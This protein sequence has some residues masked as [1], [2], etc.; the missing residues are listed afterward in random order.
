[1]AAQRAV[2]AQMKA[3]SSRGRSS[4]YRAMLAALTCAFYGCASSGSP[5][6][7]VDA[8]SSDAAPETADA[9]FQRSEP[10]SA[11]SPSSSARGDAADAREAAELPWLNRSHVGT[12]VRAHHGDFQACQALGDLESRRE[13]GAITVGWLVRPDGGVNAVTVGASTF[14]SAR[15]NACVLGVAKQ[16]TFPPSAAPSQVSW[17]VKFRGASHTPL[18]TVH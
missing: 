2:Q 14:Q 17:T 18:A 9:S 6:R 15:I 12:A 13:D 4:A 3:A 1:M 16:V 5:A 11:A 8:V 10:V 7:S